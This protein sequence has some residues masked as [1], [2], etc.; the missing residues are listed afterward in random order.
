MRPVVGINGQWPCPPIN[1]N[2]G[3]RVVVKVN[4]MLGNESTS[5]HFHGLYQQGSATMDGPSGVNQ[6]P[7]P[8]GSKFTY[9]FKVRFSI[10]WLMR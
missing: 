2:I 7:I 9:D 8:P 3:D 4:N 5:L 10:F 6:C 1:A